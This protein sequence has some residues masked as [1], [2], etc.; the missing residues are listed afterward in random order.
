MPGAAPRPRP[1]S[2]PHSH[3][4]RRFHA[5]AP[6]C[7]ACLKCAERLPSVSRSKS[8]ICVM[9]E[10]EPFPRAVLPSMTCSHHVHRRVFL[11]LPPRRVTRRQ[12]QQPRSSP[13]KR[14]RTVHPFPA[15]KP[16]L[17]RSRRFANP[18]T[19]VPQKLREKCFRLPHILE[20]PQPSTPYAP[21]PSSAKSTPPKA[22]PCRCALIPKPAPLTI[23]AAFVPS[24][25]SA[26]FSAACRLAHAHTRARAPN[27]AP[28]QPFRRTQPRFH[29]ASQ[30]IGFLLAFRRSRTAG[31]S[32]H[33][34]FPL[35]RK[36]LGPKPPRVFSYQSPHL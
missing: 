30:H 11:F 3:S 27:H 8:Q 31:A 14:R 25:F 7:G 22:A 35:Q 4:L 34:L 5:P 19:A 21:L 33:S 28:Q 10:P 1:P 32:Q 29:R 13:A 16:W 6:F 15:Q 20:A 24:C 2:L 17:A 36:L 26:S 9:A 23:R 18:R 12:A